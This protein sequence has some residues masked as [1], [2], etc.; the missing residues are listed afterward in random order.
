[1]RPIALAAV[2]VAALLAP[3]PARAGGD[4][5]LVVQP[6]ADTVVPG[7][8]VELKVLGRLHPSG[9]ASVLVRAAELDL[10]ARGG[11]TVAPATADPG[12]T[13]WV[14]RAPDAVASDLA[15]TVEARVRAYPESSGACAIRVKA[16]AAPKPAAPAPG[17]PGPAPKPAEADEDGDLVDGAEAMDADPVGNLCTLERWRVKADTGDE[18][19][20][21]KK[22]PPR[23]ESMN[24]HA[25][26]QMFRIRVNR[27]DVKSVEVQWWRNDRKKRVRTYHERNRQLDVERDQ[28]GL[29][30]VTFKKEMGKHGEAYTFAIVVATSDGKT[31]RENLVVFWGGEKREEKEEKK[32]DK[33]R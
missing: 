2:V 6:A 14:Y 30:H 27:K 1:M 22:V 33:K 25:P 7:G 3:A 13:R 16:P 23:G 17:A 19:W 21:D 4:D 31:Q 20:V 24:A 28:D 15:V 10:T 5:S 29:P 18:K 8:T 26:I 9:K 32:G 12:E 11:G